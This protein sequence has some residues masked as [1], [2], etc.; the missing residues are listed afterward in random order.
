M[1]V[2]D[3]KILAQVPNLNMVD[4]AE[5]DLVSTGTAPTLVCLPRCTR[6]SGALP[7]RRATNPTLPALTERSVRAPCA[8]AAV[9]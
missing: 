3:T 7:T 1:Y 4:D 9:V 6:P 2:T 5:M 8:A